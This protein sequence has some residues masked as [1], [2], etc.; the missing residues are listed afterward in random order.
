MR[1]IVLASSSPTRKRIL[2]DLGIQFQVDPSNYEEDMTLPMPPKE[3]VMHLS[4]G[5]A[6]E[7]A[8]KHED[9]LVI[10]AD[11][12]I[13]YKNE[14]LGKPYTP[15]RAFE[16]LRMLSGNTH[17]AITGYTIIDTK[18]NRNISRAVVTQVVFR[19]LTDK[20]INDY[21]ATGEPLNKAGSYAI[22]ENGKNLVKE[23]I[24]SE[25]NVAGLP[26]EDLLETLKELE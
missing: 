13:F 25:T 2:D 6:M 4:K 23:F 19:D 14:R 17:E 11:T 10:G 9:A 18:N 24:G 22:L 16:M 20:E 12:V 1:K 5:K 21:I 3:L 26:V 7:V 15:E 8:R